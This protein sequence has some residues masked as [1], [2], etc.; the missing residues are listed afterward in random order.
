MFSTCMEDSTATYYGI[1]LLVM[2]RWWNRQTR[3]VEGHVGIMARAGSSPALGT[4]KVPEGAI[5]F[6]TFIS[7]SKS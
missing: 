7:I 5:F 6:G 1:I 4:N 2:P 3:M